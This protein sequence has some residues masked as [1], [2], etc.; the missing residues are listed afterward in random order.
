MTEIE[1]VGRNNNEHGT[2]IRNET[3][4]KVLD[5]PLPI[6]F[7]QLRGF[8]ELVNYFRDHVYANHSVV[9]KP[10]QKLLEGMNNPTRKLE[11]TDRAT[12]AFFKIKDLI[13]LQAQ[14]FFAN[15]DDL[16]YL[17]TDASDYGIGGDLYQLVAIPIAFVSK[18]LTGAQF[19]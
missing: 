13:S 2:I 5:F 12:Q 11:W 17:L 4:T 14:L 9:V 19:R 10:L 18:S 6:Y 7:K 1:Y 16:I 3:M 15:D 8:I